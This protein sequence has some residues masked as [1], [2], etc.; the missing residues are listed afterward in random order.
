MPANVILIIDDEPKIRTLLSRILELEGYTVYEAENGKAG[1]AALA[2]REIQ[3]VICDVSLPDANGIEMVTSIKSKYPSVEIIMFTG[4]GTI[5]DG[6]AA[7][8]NGAFDY[9]TKGTDNDKIIPTVARAFEK[10]SLQRRIRSL[11]SQ[12]NIKFSFANIIGKSKPFRD[13]LSLAARVAATD[14]SVLLLGES[15]TG[16]EV[17][18]HA[19][20]N[21]GLRR[22]K[23]FVALNCSA[24]SKELLESELF[25]YKAGAFTG[26]IREKTGLLEEANEGTLFLDEIGEMDLDLQAKLLRVIEV[27]EFYK[28]GDSKPTKVNLRFI[29]ATNRELLKEAERGAF[30]IDLFYRLSVFQIRLP[31]L[32]ERREDIDL[33]TD[34]F[35]KFY[36]DKVNRKVRHTTDEF[37]EIL[38][39]QKW[40]GNIRE[41]KNV[42]ER[43]VIMME[44]DELTKDHLP[45]EFQLNI[46]KDASVDGYHMDNII[47]AHIVKVLEVTGGNKTETARLLGIGLST[48]YRKLEEYKVE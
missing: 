11:Q 46:N 21:E 6:V 28:V 33:L 40:Q 16:K 20:H 34:Y 43:A 31:A 4:H 15:G 39:Y 22:D 14:T 9:I 48:L 36:A 8:K 35:V 19:I 41:L 26:A 2:K 27:G 12:I 7:I 38:H 23:N 1:F 45:L 30:R 47:K 44:G 10:V 37:R 18:A 3:V 29:A 24:F 25:G 5:Q 13:A 17:F 32:R 42:L